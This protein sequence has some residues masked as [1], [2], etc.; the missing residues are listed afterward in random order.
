LKDSNASFK[1]KTTK[2]EII[3]VHFL[4][5]STSEVEGRAG[6]LGWGLGKMTSRSIIHIDLHELN[7]KFVSVELEHFWCTDEPWAYMDFTM[8]QIWGIYHLP[9]LIIFSVPSHWGCTQMSFCLR[10]FKLEVLKFSKLGF[11]QL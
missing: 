11:L 3:G 7:N 1:V 2:E 9:L 4:T 8:A 5:Q 10:T 6:A